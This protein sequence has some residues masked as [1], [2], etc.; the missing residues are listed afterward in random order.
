MDF[1]SKL[2]LPACLQEAHEDLMGGRGETTWRPGSERLGVPSIRLRGTGPKSVHGCHL[3]PYEIT[4]K[5]TAW[6]CTKYCLISTG[7]HCHSMEER[8]N[9]HV[10]RGGREVGLSMR[11][12]L[13]QLWRGI[14]LLPA[15]VLWASDGPGEPRRRQDT[16]SHPE[17]PDACSPPPLPRQA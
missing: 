9:R 12:R 3:S 10:R 17:G 16:H 6:G 14:S 4:W 11:T 1:H 13:S 7:H 5:S 15:G 8:R 2:S